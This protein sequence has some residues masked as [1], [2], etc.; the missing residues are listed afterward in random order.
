MNVL[1]DYS[2]VCAC[3]LL[4]MSYVSLWSIIVTCHGHIPLFYY[5][6]QIT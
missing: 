6:I 4:L 2:S 1:H 5:T 3:A